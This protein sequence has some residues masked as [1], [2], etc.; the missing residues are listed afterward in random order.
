M[1]TY[2]FGRVIAETRY[3]HSQQ[4][5]DKLHVIFLEIRIFGIYIRQTPNPHQCAFRAVGI[6]GDRVKTVGM[7]KLVTASGSFHHLVADQVHIKGCVIGKHIDKH[8]HVICRRRIKHSLHLLPAAYDVVS[9]SPCRRLI[10]MI[11]VALP[12]FRVENFFVSPFRAVTCLHRRS[13][14]HGE[15]GISNLFHVLGNGWKIPTPH[16]QDAL[17]IGGIGIVGNAVTRHKRR[18][19]QSS[20]TGAKQQFFHDY[21]QQ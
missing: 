7:I 20:R 17:C 5:I 21:S 19:C 4:I 15:S 1:H 12:T 3:S 6:I 9:D 13:L 10:V 11:P 2:M 8:T 18:K 16:M 14:N